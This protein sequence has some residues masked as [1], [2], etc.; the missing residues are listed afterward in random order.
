MAAWLSSTLTFTLQNGI[1]E[2]LHY[3]PLYLSPQYKEKAFQLKKSLNIWGD[4]YA[5][6][7]LVLILPMG[8]TENCKTATKKL[9]QQHMTWASG[10]NTSFLYHPLSYVRLTLGGTS[11][12]EIMVKVWCSECTATGWSWELLANHVT[13]SRADFHP[14]Y[15][16]SGH[17]KIQR[18][19]E[20]EENV[21]SRTFSGAA[22]RCNL[23]CCYE[24]TLICDLLLNVDCEM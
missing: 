22:T 6:V 4:I 3:G 7:D 9:F 24:W 10:T 11:F 8:C 18:W 14:P 5:S 1:T 2:S 21:S 13:S 20:G 15:M 12:S 23:I 16:S 17:Q 19:D